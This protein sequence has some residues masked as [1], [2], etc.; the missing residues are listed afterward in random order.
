[1]NLN[2]FFI[3]RKFVTLSSKFKIFGF[4]KK[5]KEKKKR[6]DILERIS[7]YLRTQAYILVQFFDK[8]IKIYRPRS[9]YLWD[10]GIA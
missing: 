9:T 8:L 4:K 10:V 7:T 3:T 2:E 6:I 5:K 1:M